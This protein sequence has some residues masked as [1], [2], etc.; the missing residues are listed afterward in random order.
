MRCLP[1]PFLIPYAMC[2]P[3]WVTRYAPLSKMPIM[4]RLASLFLS[5]VVAVAVLVP[6]LRPPTPAVT[7]PPL[8]PVKARNGMVVSAHIDASEAGVEILKK[9]GNAVDAAVATGFALA[10]VYPV[11]GNIGGG[12]FM[13]LRGADGATTTYDYR[14]KAP[15]AAFRDMYLDEQGNFVPER[16]QKGYLA[17]GVPGSVAGMLKAHTAHG[18]LPLAEVMAPAIRLAEGGFVLSEEQADRFNA[19]R[20][21]FSEFEAT[22]KYFAKADS[23]Q[24]FQAGEVFTQRDLAEVLKRIRD[25][26]RDGFYKGVTAELI[27]ADMQRHGGIITRDDLE[28]YEAIERP[29][30]V[31]TYRGYRV[32]SMAPPSS[33]GIALLQL[34]NA[35]EPYPMRDLAYNGSATV[36]LMGEAMRRAYADRAEWLGDPDFFEVPLSQLTD[37]Q[38]TR[39]RMAD[40]NPYRADS[41]AVLGHGDPVAWE[42]SETTHYSVVDAEGNAVSVTTT[43]NGGYGSGV[44]IEGAGFFMNNEMDD[45]SAKPGVPNMFGL[46][47]NEANAIQPGKRMLSSMTPTIVEDPQGRLFMV[48][49]TPGGSTIITTVFQVI[50]N[51]V[52]HRMNIQQAVAAPRI[53]HQWLPDV[54]R[55]ERFALSPDA[56]WNLELRGWTVTEGGYWGQADGIVV[57]YEQF[58]E[59]TDPSSVGTSRTR[60]AG[61][62]YHGG[63]DPRGENAAVGY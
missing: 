17:S 21:M 54:M 49:G 9:G 58:R 60:E 47:G 43:I 13:V 44:V 55:A 22:K 2:V 31:G 12:G 29:P 16:S 33:G 62:I 52:D 26:G 30:V 1:L 18:R 7:V 51:V 63:A 53:H 57:H 20:R 32:I 41:S 61:R 11:A 59:Q 23:T 6:T 3:I 19:H 56:R 42:S 48:I 40:F 34:L 35:V 28:A 8:D 36:H 27:V 45:F 39:T 50:V 25:H 24:R 46:V 37:K 38:Y 14:E 5:A 10:V 4:N 15:A